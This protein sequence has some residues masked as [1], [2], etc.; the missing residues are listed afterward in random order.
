MLIM[1]GAKEVSKL[2]FTNINNSYIVISIIEVNADIFTKY[3]IDVIKSKPRN[4]GINAKDIC[5]NKY[6][7]NFNFKLS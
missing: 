3:I 7:F 5:L 1:K 4:I 2:S 6:E